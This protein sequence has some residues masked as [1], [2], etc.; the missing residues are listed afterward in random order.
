MSNEARQKEITPLKDETFYNTVD[1]DDRPM[2]WDDIV[3]MVSENPHS[4]DN[5]PFFFT[6]DGIGYSVKEIVAMIPDVID[7]F[8]SED[9]AQAQNRYYEDCCAHV[10]V[11]GV[12]LDVEKGYFIKYKLKKN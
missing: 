2:S 7:Y 5:E 3:D 10:N 6:S 11:I 1:G 4:T 8:G 9:E 12:G